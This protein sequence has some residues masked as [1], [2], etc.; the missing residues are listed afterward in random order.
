MA[1]KAT[2]IPQTPTPPLE[3]LTVQNLRWYLHGDPLIDQVSFSLY[4]GQRIGLIGSN[5]C[6]KSTLLRLLAGQLLPG[7]GRI[8]KTPGARLILLPQ[9][10][11][12]PAQK[13]VLQTARQSLR[14]LYELEALLRQEEERLA[15]GEDRLDTYQALIEQFEQAGGYRA[16]HNLEKILS[17]L[18]FHPADYARATTSLSGGERARLEL[19]TALA[20]HADVLLLD[21]PTNYLDLSTRHR[22]A[23]MLATFKGGLMMAS[24]DRALLD[25][26]CTH[27]A[28]LSKGRLELSRGNYRRYASQRELLTRSNQKRAK[29]RRKDEERIRETVAQLQSWGTAKA[30]RHR[31]RLERRMKVADG[32]PS[33]TGVPTFRATEGPT[34]RGPVATATHL[35]KRWGSTF[36]VDDVAFRIE[37]GD[38]IALLGPNGSGKSTFLKLIGGELDSDDPGTEFH[39]HPDGKLAYFDRE[40]GLNP[41]TPLLEQL[42]QTISKERARTLLALV[43]IE[44]RRWRS[45]PE[46]L[47]GGERARVALANVMATE[48]SLLL[49]DE[50]TNH[51]DLAAIEQLERA[52]VDLRAAVLF[53]THDQRLVERVATR[54]WTLRE[55]DLLEFRGGIDGFFND[56]L[57]I[58]RESNLVL[59]TDDEVRVPPSPRQEL[60][61]LEEEL[62][63]L[64]VKL[65]DPTRLTP[66]DTARLQRCRRD[67]L[68]RLEPLY[69]SLLSPPRPTF[70]V[71]EP[72]VTLWAD[73]TPGGLAV[74]APPP[75]AVDVLYQQ[76]IAH[77]QLEEPS[78]SC[79][80]PWARNAIVRATV[81]I[82]FYALGA[83]IVQIQSTR[84]LKDTLLKPAGHDWWLLSRQDFEALEGWEK[85]GAVAKRRRLYHHPDWEAWASWRRWVARR[86]QH[87]DST[88]A[89]G[90]SH[91][92]ELTD[93]PI[94]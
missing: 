71:V 30:Q 33:P 88:C 81:R 57:R 3:L 38:K 93:R 66:R 89:Y 22:L 92:Q 7:E 69:D 61:G 94:E 91:L 55:G 47:S 20:S 67:L 56:R 65:E 73:R 79:L 63:A 15:G 45:P 42:E 68:E 8:R 51:L 24:H 14:Y 46:M 13:T 78:E 29:E 85:P 53:I 35:T 75:V 28:H 23:N 9:D 60:E 37:A 84:D 5:G 86:E 52:L 34:L 54:I 6:G 77:L 11:S 64:E 43:G 21:E 27:I 87:R 49:L 26:V 59:E 2:G 25:T 40:R 83:R 17:R 1:H 31:K 39:W 50:P 44:K 72:G 32:A 16:E 36:W 80:L 58:N 70:K 48:A 76:D 4:S 62:V 19:A 41:G 74:I 90:R 10:F 18:G 12:S 82:A